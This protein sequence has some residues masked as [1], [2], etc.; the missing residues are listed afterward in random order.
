[1]Q[2]PILSNPYPCRKT[3]GSRE[4]RTP[5]TGRTQD[6]HRPCS[7]SQQATLAE[8]KLGASETEC[9]P[10]ALCIF[11]SNGYCMDSEL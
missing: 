2:V 9:P 6:E 1:M 8:T 5:I 4:G 10:G 7:A 11:F 3:Q